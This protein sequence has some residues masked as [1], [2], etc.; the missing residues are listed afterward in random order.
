VCCAGRSNGCGTRT[1]RCKA[2][3]RSGSSMGSEGWRI[4]RCTVTRLM[5][6]LEILGITRGKC[7]KTTIRD[8]AL[9]WTISG[10]YKAEVIHRRSRKNPQ[11]V[12][13]ARL[14]WVD[15]FNH[16]RLLG[17]IGNIPP[18][19]VEAAY[20]RKQITLVIALRVTPNGLR[21]SRGYS[22]RAYAPPKRQCLHH[23]IPHRSRS[24]TSAYAHRRARTSDH[25]LDRP[26]P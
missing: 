9:T 26:H 21:D 19:E 24:I 25:K 7:V 20:Y 2:R 4:A 18:V 22:S 1:G 10:L 23:K 6:R 16:K 11:Q 5:R 12:E 17:P 8:K 15:W 13:L 3:A 14:D